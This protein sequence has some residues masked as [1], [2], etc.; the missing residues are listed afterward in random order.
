MRKLKIFI[1]HILSF[2]SAHLFVIGILGGCAILQAFSI[3]L[4]DTLVS[5]LYVSAFGI[6]DLAF[7]FLWGLFF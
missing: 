2:S 5:G 7:N 3:A 4:F 1:E 6:R